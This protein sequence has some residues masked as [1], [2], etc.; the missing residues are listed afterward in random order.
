MNF[1]T[2]FRSLSKLI[3]NPKSLLQG[4]KTLEFQGKLE[5]L[6]GGK[7]E[8]VPHARIGLYLI[9]NYLN[10]D[11]GSEVLMTPI[12]L[13]EMLKMI[14]ANGLVTQF[15]GYQNNSF[16]LNYDEVKISPKTKVFLY[17]PIAGI[18]ADMDKLQ[19]FCNRN[20]L[21]LVQDLTQSF[22]ASWKNKPVQ[23]YARY[24]FLSLCDLKVIHTHRGGIIQTADLA[25]R[26]WFLQKERLW[27][28]K[29]SR[30]YFFSFIFED[31]ISSLLLRRKFFNFAGRLILFF[32]SFLGAN[33]IEDLTAGRG[34]KIGP[35]RFLKS[36]MASGN[37]W[38]SNEIPDEQKYRYSELQAEIGIS[39]LEKLKI[40]EQKR[41][42]NAKLFYNSLNDQARKFIPE[43]TDDPGHVFWKTPVIIPQFHKFQQM[44][45]K[46]KVDFARSNLPW[47]P[48]LLDNQNVTGRILR[49]SCVYFPTHYYL[50]EHEIL[51][52]AESLNHCADQSHES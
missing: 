8:L 51:A 14:R 11:P 43:F 10:L 4:P 52:M 3:F 48:D 33:V 25:F 13:P 24:N 27:L 19:E 49:E 28:K 18:H 23:N 7:V 26:S 16:E 30:K 37:D 39:R 42:K 31:L 45:L 50:P 36:F 15:I 44:L 21:I 47:L 40:R 20:K 9:L 17:T 32:T 22:L 41:I 29:P 6:F 2:P 1:W 46:R 12:N 35:F 5:T 34:L 38:K